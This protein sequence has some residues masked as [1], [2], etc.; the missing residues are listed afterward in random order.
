MLSLQQGPDTLKQ[1]FVKHTTFG[2]HE[3]P[4][5]FQTSPSGQPLAFK[6]VQ[7]WLSDE[8][9]EA[10]SPELEDAPLPQVRLL[11]LEFCRD[12]FAPCDTCCTCPFGADGR[13]DQARLARK[14]TSIGS[15][16]EPAVA[17]GAERQDGESAGT[18]DARW[19]ELV[20]V[21]L[22]PGAFSWDGYWHQLNQGDCRDFLHNGARHPECRLQLVSGRKN[23]LYIRY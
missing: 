13:E 18:I 10:I 11:Q 20:D 5:C 19:H 12:V 17:T 4:F 21:S 6:T 1:C 9:L 22:D 15:E 23:R 16:E 3:I 14:E 8:S 7:R 2:E